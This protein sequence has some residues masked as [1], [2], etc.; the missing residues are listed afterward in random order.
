MS[1]R[2][3][4]SGCAIF[5]VLVFSFFSAGSISAE[6]LNPHPRLWMNKGKLNKLKLSVK[7]NTQRW[8]RFTQMLKS[9]KGGSRPALAFALAYLVTGNTGY[10]KKAVVATLEIARK[11]PTKD[12]NELQFDLEEVAFAYDY[13]YKMFSA[14]EKKEVVKYV[15][16]GYDLRKDFNIR[17]AWHNYN[18]AY[19]YAFAV[20]GIAT[21][22][23][24]PRSGELIKNARNRFKNHILPAMK[25][26]GTRGAWLESNGYGVETARQ[27]VG[28]AYAI[29]T[30][31]IKNEN[32]FKEAEGWFKNR[33]LYHVLSDLPGG[34]TKW[35]H[36][37]RDV[38]PIGD[39]HRK[40][41]GI[42]SYGRAT[43]LMLL[44]NYQKEPWAPPLNAYLSEKPYNQLT[45]KGG[46]A[47]EFLLY[48][49]D[50]KKGEISDL[51]LS[52]CA[53]EAGHLFAR[54][55]WKKDA[56]HF[57]FTCGDHFSYHQHLDQNSFQIYLGQDALA[58]DGGDYAGQRDD[59]II[60]YANRTVAHNSILVYD[61][62]EKFRYRH[63]EAVNDGG[64]RGFKEN[65]Y[66]SLEKVTEEVRRKHFESGD[67]IGFL[68]TKDFLYVAGDAT[69]AYSDK[70]LKSFVRRIV[71]IRP[72][73]FIILDKV[74]SKKAEYKKT[75]LLHTVN[76]PELKNGLISALSGGAK[77]VM[78]S[79][80]PEK[81][82]VKIIGGPGKE[83]FVAGKNRTP[84]KGK[85][86]GKY[87]RIEIVDETGEKETYFLNIIWAMKVSE[88]FQGKATLSR[89]GK[90]FQVTLSDKTEVLFSPTGGWVKKDGK[91][92]KF[93]DKIIIPKTKEKEMK[94][95][96]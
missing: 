58:V 24:N 28:Y 91:T 6:D 66:H 37:W 76:K 55:G 44:E 39:H 82:E 87:W 84:P 51:P 74:I 81:R 60:N 90:D 54:S 70:K 40:Q 64:Q 32:P 23:D 3:Q 95:V 71:Y 88:K 47:F 68:E 38:V 17:Y 92:V 22:G 43:L 2:I 34:F 93:E 83:Y 89:K 63:K 50:I 10:G 26:N 96:E 46:A 16:A 13:A 25:R 19:M 62:D 59:Y 52:W 9:E 1:Y 7:N 67:F 86:A 15:N 41:Q 49:P 5:F 11:P 56:V 75:F 27:F 72:G 57:T 94:E 69:K 18:F 79:F 42:A 20:A 73:T 61:K 78:Q 4:V 31:G 80:L 65:E 77:L 53:P 14:S 85:K 29:K 36:Y 45:H 33:A 48:D 12:K 8:K 30:S 35:D 21:S